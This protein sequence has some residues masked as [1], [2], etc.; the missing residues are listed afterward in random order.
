[1]EL[2]MALALILNVV[3]VAINL[4]KMIFAFRNG[5]RDKMAEWLFAICCGMLIFTLATITKY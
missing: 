3:C 1:M 4:A 2:I 5:E